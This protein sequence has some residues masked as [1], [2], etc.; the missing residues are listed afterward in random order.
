MRAHAESRRSA[1][2]RVAAKINLPFES[3]SG[4]KDSLHC[5]SMSSVPGTQVGA[6][7]APPPTAIAVALASVYLVWGSTYLFIRLAVE[8]YP[9]LLMA[10]TR[11]T[12]SGLL[13]LAWQWLR[14]VPMPTAVQWR[15]CAVIGALL[16]GI[17]NGLVCYAEQS[18]ASA[19]A[20]IVIAA[21]PAWAG[22]FSWLYGQRL[23]RTEWTGIAIGFVGVV[24]LNLGGEFDADPVGM[25][26]L[27]IASVAWAFGSIWGRGRDLPSPFTATA[28][29]MLCAGVILLAVGALIG[30]RYR[31][32][33]PLLATLSLLYL[34]FIGSLVGFGAYVYLL[35]H[36]R[37]ALATS[38]AYVN[39]PIAVL[40]GVFLAGE[41]L[42]PLTV[43]A[44][45]VILVG[46]AFISLRPKSR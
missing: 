30:E 42:Q 16:L 20:A 32:D 21:V 25:A 45:A 38:Y 14:G 11:F 9:P 44:M 4:K 43:A 17:G 26:M 1:Y 6:A 41:S 31:P 33:P 29:Q 39:P 37:P 19:V 24:L 23:V 5:S 8:G 27:A 13:L 34:T 22:V 35:A 2:I 7:P 15:N 10:G 12:A 28:A 3:R 18:V 40:L 36:A 46:V